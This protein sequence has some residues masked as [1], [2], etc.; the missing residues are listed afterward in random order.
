MRRNFSEQETKQ[1]LEKLKIL[2]I[3]G[4]SAEI[5]YVYGYCKSFEEHKA[6]KGVLINLPEHTNINLH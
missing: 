6:D 3:A 2:L 5:G 4:I 1:I